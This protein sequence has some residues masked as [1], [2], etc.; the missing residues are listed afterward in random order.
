MQRSA[1]SGV[2]DF[3]EVVVVVQT[4]CLGYLKDTVSLLLAGSM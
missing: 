2:G 3:V 4:A 1:F